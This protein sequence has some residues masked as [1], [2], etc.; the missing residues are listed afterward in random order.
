VTA[1]K[2]P[3]QRIT[4]GYNV[5][6]AAKEAWVLASGAAKIDALKVSL[7]ENSNTPFGRVLKS[8]SYTKVFTDIG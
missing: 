8:R 1:T 2:P 5:I 3:P 4:V 7:E 6:A